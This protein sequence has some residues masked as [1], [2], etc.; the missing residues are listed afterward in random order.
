MRK[1]ILKSSLCILATS[2]I[3]VTSLA[4]ERLP[5]VEAE[6]RRVDQNT[7][8][9]TLRHGDIPNLDMPPMTMVFVVDEPASMDGI[10]VGDQ[11]VVTIEQ[12][13]G[14]YRVRSIR[15]APR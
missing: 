12:V 15:T 13:K 1:V 6:V 3:S 8:K 5:E 4:D 9:I 7:G 14:A 10:E 11:V 2:L